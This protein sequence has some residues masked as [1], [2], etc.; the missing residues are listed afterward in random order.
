MI[1]ETIQEGRQDPPIDH[2]QG[3][4]S[5]TYDS[6]N[7]LTKYT[8]RSGVSY[9]LTY[10]G[11]NRDASTVTSDGVKITYTYD[12]AGNVTLSKTQATSGG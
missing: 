3:K 6:S 2:G 8:S 10:S 9:S 7:R 1:N 5:T 12:S 4:T 11:T